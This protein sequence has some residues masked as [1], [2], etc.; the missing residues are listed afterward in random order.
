MPRGWGS[1]SD[2]GLRGREEG[3]AGQRQGWAHYAGEE[4][5]E[6]GEAAR[7]RDRVRAGEVVGWIPPRLRVGPPRRLI[8]CHRSFHSLTFTFCKGN[9]FDMFA[10]YQQRGDSFMQCVQTHIVGGQHVV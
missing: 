5:V 4:G 8:S 7:D 1:T 9:S 2:W 3:G 6:E 10:D